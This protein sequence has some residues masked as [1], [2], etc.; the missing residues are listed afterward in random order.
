M[1]QI[2]LPG[3]CILLAFKFLI[4]RHNYMTANPY[5]CAGMENNLG[6]TGDMTRNGTIVVGKG[7][8]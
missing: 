7:G 5:P 3:Q 1:Q 8:N 2:R 6:S 4:C